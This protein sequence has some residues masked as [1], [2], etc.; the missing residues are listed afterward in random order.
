MFTYIDNILQ[1]TFRNIEESEVLH[2]L[3]FM[4]AFVEI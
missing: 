4:T 2:L 3:S 1:R